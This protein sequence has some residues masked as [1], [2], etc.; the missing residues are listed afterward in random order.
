MG[1]IEDVLARRFEE[2]GTRF[3]PSVG[4]NSKGYARRWRYPEPTRPQPELCESAGC[5]RAATDLDHDHA[6]NKFR[7]WLC[8]HCNKALGF[9]L[10]SPERLRALADYLERHQATTKES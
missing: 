2:D 6:T 3:G 8:G 7:G 4:R 1:Y 5:D 9:T 10:D